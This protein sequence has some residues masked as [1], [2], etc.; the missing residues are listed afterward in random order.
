MIYLPVYQPAY[1]YYQSG[2]ALGFGVAFAI[3]PWLN[4]DFDW[5][6]HH[7]FFWDR[8][9]PRPANW[10]R[11]QPAQRQTWLASQGAVWRP[12]DHRGIAPARQGDRGWVNPA[13]RPAQPNNIIVNMSRPAPVRETGTFHVPSTPSPGHPAR[14]RER[15]HWQRECARREKLQHSRPGKHADGHAAGTGPC[16]TSPRRARPYRGAGFAPGSRLRRWR[17]RWFAAKT[18]INCL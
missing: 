2:Y 3:G 13:S 12:E 8:N 4:C 6:R 15:V 11:E 17:R 14:A 5:H 18:L 10:W 16:R 9:H 7:L 1:I